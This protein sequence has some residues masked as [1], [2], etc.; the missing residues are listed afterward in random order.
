MTWPR[1]TR[2]L[3]N[4]DAVELTAMQDAAAVLLDHE[5]HISP[6]VVTALCQIR[7]ETAAALNARDGQ[8][9]AGPRR[10]LHTVQQPA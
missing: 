6:D 10:Y 4:A 2:N 1:A 3:N 7:E 5:R 8:Q 9:Q